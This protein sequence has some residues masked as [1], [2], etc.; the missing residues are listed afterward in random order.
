MTIQTCWDADRLDLGRVGMMP[1]PR[2]LSTEIA[3]RRDTICWA[4]GRAALGFIPE[5]VKRE[6]GIDLE[7]EREG[8]YGT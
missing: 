6:W 2:F 8:Y 7:G 3:K 5:I 1:D 4:D